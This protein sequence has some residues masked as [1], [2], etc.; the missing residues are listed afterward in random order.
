MNKE[1]DKLI[2]RLKPILKEK[3]ISCEYFETDKEKSFHWRNI[4]KDYN[5]KER[6]WRDY[7]PF[8]N[9]VVVSYDKIHKFVVVVKGGAGIFIERDLEKTY[10]F[11]KLL[12]IEV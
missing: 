12:E 6:I 2:E 1:F 11:I 4:G 5:K 8:V 7:Y 3:Y 10:E 9:S